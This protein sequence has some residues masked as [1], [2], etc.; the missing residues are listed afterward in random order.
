MADLKPD[1]VFVSDHPSHALENKPL[2]QSRPVHRLI[3]DYLSMIGFNGLVAVLSFATTSLLLRYMGRGNYGEVVSLTSTSL[4]LT[5]LGTEWTSQS[6]V[7]F[8]TEE[9]LA[10]GQV[11]AYFWNRLAICGAAVALILISA[12]LW[13]RLLATGLGFTWQGLLFIGFYFPS[14]VFWTHLQRV[15]PSIQRHK[16]LYPLLSLER[17]VVLA[18]AT[19]L[20]LSGQLRIN[21][22][23][24]GYIAGCL[25][26]TGLAVWLI[27][28]EI[29]RPVWPDLAICRTIIGYSWPLIPTSIVGLLS[30]NTLDY[31]MIRRFVGT[32]E[33]GVYALAVQIAGIVQQV[34]QIAGQLAA[35]RVVAMRLKND[36]AGIMNLIYRQIVP[37]LW[38][39]SVCCLAGASLVWWLGPQWLPAK[40]LLI[41]DLAWPLAAVTSIVPVWYIVWSPLITAY[42]Q[43][44]VVM[45]ASVATGVVNVSAN[46]ILIPQIGV[47]GSAWATVL[48]FSMTVY[49]TML[50]LRG[51]SVLHTIGN[52]VFHIPVLLS[53]TGV[54]IQCQPALVLWAVIAAFGLIVLVGFQQLEK[55][56]RRISP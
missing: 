15:L 11:R 41:R 4:L 54:L 6:L 13:G 1:P 27:R 51:H 43:V 2:A 49:L 48:A 25:L 44:R 16:L 19:I 39:W 23:L 40:Y 52:P 32:A 31:L 45:W 10:T 22:F 36:L 30:T 55:Q 20:Q 37:V 46:L 7:R 3:R 53:A 8:G 26:S 38:C 18:F 35:P 28:R 9:F 21:I 12:P 5:M 47:I 56:R 42:E 34:P 24:P 29:G 50:L 14:Q 17:F 33:L